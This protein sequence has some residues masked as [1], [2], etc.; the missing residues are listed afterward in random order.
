MVIWEKFN[1]LL[2]ASLRNVFV[3]KVF[4]CTAICE[5]TQRLHLSLMENF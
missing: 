3:L 5:A 1:L 2:K 4:K